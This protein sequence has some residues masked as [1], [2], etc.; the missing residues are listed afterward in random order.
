MRN[1]GPDTNWPVFY[2]YPK[3]LLGM[4]L[5][6][7]ARTVY[8]LLFD[9]A[10]LSIQN[11]W[12]DQDGRVFLYYTEEHL[13]ADLNRTEATIRTALRALEG[14][15]L[16]KRKRQGAGRPNR[17]YVYFPEE[18]EIYDRKNDRSQTASK[19]TYSKNES[20]N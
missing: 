8:M 6:E 16:V 17:I 15:G 20:K 14:L 18:A 3:F 19:L 9:R 7:T 1:L 13:A 10:K 4:D 12:L 2:M 5:N 11:G